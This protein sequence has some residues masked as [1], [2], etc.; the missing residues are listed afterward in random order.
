MGKAAKAH[1]KKVQAR[2]QRIKGEQKKMQKQYQEMFEKQMLEFQ[3]KFSADTI[4]EQSIGV[5][6]NGQEMPFEVINSEELEKRL[7]DSGNE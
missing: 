6:V 5:N 1:R 2:N 4:D 7:E 3:N